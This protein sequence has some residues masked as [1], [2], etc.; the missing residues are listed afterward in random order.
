TSSIRSSGRITVDGT[1]YRGNILF[2]PEKDHMIVVNEVSVEEYLYSVVATEVSASWPAESLKAQSVAARTYAYYNILH[3]RSPG[4]FDLY[5]DVRSQAY[6]GT[7]RE[8]A[9]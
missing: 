8:D 5:D 7:V 9:R 3:P 2:L 1:S 6:T 4:K